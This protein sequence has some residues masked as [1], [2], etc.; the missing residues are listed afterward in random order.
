[1]AALTSGKALVR[2]LG[3]GHLLPLVLLVAFGA[4]A[5]P[6]AGLIVLIGG[7]LLKALL[8]LQ[9]GQFRPIAIDAMQAPLSLP[10]PRRE[11]S[12]T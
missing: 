11:R 1:M 3:V 7:G 2:I 5:L 10:L 6:P 12:E 8:I 9:A 4:A